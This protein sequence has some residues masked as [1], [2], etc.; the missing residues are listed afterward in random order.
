M[1]REPTPEEWPLIRELH[2]Q[3][4]AVFDR[5]EATPAAQAY[6][7]ILIAA[8]YSGRAQIPADIVFAMLSGYIMRGEPI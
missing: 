6:A 7:A 4:T 1:R 2:Q 3:L 5:S 8:R